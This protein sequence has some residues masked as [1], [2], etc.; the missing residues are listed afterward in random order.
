MQ[1]RRMHHQPGHARGEQGQ[2]RTLRRSGTS[3]TAGEI[4]G[5]AGAAERD[6]RIVEYDALGY[7][8]TLRVA[9]KRTWLTIRR[10]EPATAR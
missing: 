4:Q 6:G 5:Y 9:L 8:P 2:D 7:S 3:H 1:R 10:R